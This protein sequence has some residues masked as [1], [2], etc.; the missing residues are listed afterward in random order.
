MIKKISKFLKRGSNKSKTDFF[1][2]SSG[3]QKKIINKAARDANIEQ[4]NLIKS[5]E[6]KF[7]GLKTGNHKI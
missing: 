2:L 6:N 1:S 4:S 5:Y 7:G 3:E